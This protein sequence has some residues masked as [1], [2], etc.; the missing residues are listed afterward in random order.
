LVLIEEGCGGHGKW[1]IWW[2][3]DITVKLYLEY[4]TGSHKFGILYINYGKIM[5]DWRKFYNAELV[6]IAKYN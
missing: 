6:L 4:F 5:G 2:I 1:H 3:L